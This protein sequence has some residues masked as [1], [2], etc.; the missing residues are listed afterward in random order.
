MVVNFSRRRNIWARPNMTKPA[1]TIVCRADGRSRARGEPTNER[2]Q[3]ALLL[4]QQ[5]DDN[6][7][8]RKQ[9]TKHRL[10]KQG[11]SGLGMQGNSR[12]TRKKAA[13]APGARVGSAEWE[14]GGTFV[15]ENVLQ[16]RYQLVKRTVCIV[17]VLNNSKFV[18][19]NSRA[20]WKH[21]PIKT[22]PN[23]PKK[24]IN[25]IIIQKVRD[26]QFKPLINY[27]ITEDICS[28]KQACACLFHWARPYSCSLPVLPRLKQNKFNRLMV[29]ELKYRI[30]VNRLSALLNTLACG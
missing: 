14:I 4:L 21:Q 30:L 16:I 12:I 9:Q 1:A 23:K 19:L 8:S 13:P 15:D 18:W 3:F 17:N 29:N 11:P 10:R 27:L 6:N 5:A 28:V 22:G 20:H 24:S 7:N 26:Q 25:Y 2:E